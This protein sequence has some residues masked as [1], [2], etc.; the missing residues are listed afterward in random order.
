GGNAELGNPV[1]SYAQVN[2]QAITTNSSSMIHEFLLEPRDLEDDGN[3]SESTK[4]RTDISSLPDDAY[5]VTITQKNDTVR[6]K[7]A[8]QLGLSLMSFLIGKILDHK[9][10]AN[11]TSEG[12][13]LEN[14][15]RDTS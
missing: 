4:R 11:S 14:C 12:S 6:K 15:L 7:N 2:L 10:A 8:Q 13:T 9:Y 3:Y 1:Y 5:K